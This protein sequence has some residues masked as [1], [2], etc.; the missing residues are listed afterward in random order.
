MYASYYYSASSTAADILADVVAILTGETNKAN[1]SAS[2]N[3]TSTSIDASVNV[4]GW[5]VYDASAGTN[6]QCLRAAVADNASQYKY[7]VID[8]NTAGYIFTKVYEDWNSTTHTG[9]NLAGYSAI[10]AYAQRVNVTSGGRLEIYATVRCCL[11]FSYQN[12]AWGSS[13]G[14]AWTGIVER[15]RKSPWDTV[16]NGY[17]PFM[18]INGITVS[19][20]PRTLSA[21]GTD[22][23]TS[24]AVTYLGHP[25][26]IIAG[27]P[28]APPSTVVP[29]DSDKNLG[30]MFL[31]ICSTNP[32]IGHFGGDISSLCDIYL[33]TYNY[34][35]TYDTILN[36][37]SEYIIWATGT[38]WRLAIRKG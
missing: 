30:H 11:L 4:A 18:F 36:N 15:T 32:S 14:S 19:Y 2:C 24:Y 26:G 12:N 29:I 13:T 10:A 3:Q 25:L 23:T 21:T 6:A 20:E 1:L 5:S 27:T 28:Q 17:P 34:G 16:A 7:L 9:T 22:L 33:T 38:T 31:P 35:S 37:S 8:T